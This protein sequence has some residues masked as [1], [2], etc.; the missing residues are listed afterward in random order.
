MKKLALI[1]LCA[2]PTFA[3]NN[4]FHKAGVGSGELATSAW[5]KM[6]SNAAIVSNL[7]SSLDYDGTTFSTSARFAVTGATPGAMRF[8]QGTNAG[9]GT[10]FIVDFDGG[11]KILVFPTN[12]NFNVLHATNISGNWTTNKAVD[13]IVDTRSNGFACIFSFPTNFIR[14]DSGTTNNALLPSNTVSRIR[15]ENNG[16]GQSNVSARIEYG[17]G[18]LAPVIPPAAVTN[19]VGLF[20]W[21]AADRNVTNAAG[22][23]P[24]S[25]T[26][27]IKGWRDISGHVNHAIQSTSGSR[28]TYIASGQNSLPTIHFDGGIG[29]FLSIPGGLSALNGNDT[30]FLFAAALQDDFTG[31]TRCVFSAIHNAS[32]LD[33][34][35]ATY[36]GG[37]A[38]TFTRYDGTTSKSATGGSIDSSFHTFIV[39]C[40]GTT[41]SIY[42]DGVLVGSAG[43]DV[44]VGSIS[45]DTF[46]I[47]KHLVSDLYFYGEIGEV[48]L[49]DGTRTSSVSDIQTYMKNRW[50]TP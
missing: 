9:N 33:G 28:P 1:F 12:P 15:F 19:D 23:S 2:L 30:P 46:L 26:D 42:V 50:G 5:V 24:P 39:D 44:N 43:Q 38:Y 29:Q 8:R 20:A 6:N 47:G 13:W 18:G 3:A 4:F 32:P 7:V 21:F 10:N 16:P 34:I 27:A 25:D 40:T 37:G 49:F 48:M 31:N 41:A 35:S 17:S 11:Q 14:Y 45:A 36:P 22:S